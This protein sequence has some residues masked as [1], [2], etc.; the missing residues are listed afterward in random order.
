[1]LE[2]EENQ[3]EKEKPKVTYSGT[4]VFAFL[5]AKNEDRQV[6]NLPRAS[7]G[8]RQGLS[9][10]LPTHFVLWRHNATADSHDNSEEIFPF[11]NTSFVRT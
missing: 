7:F 10:S 9:E 6:E 5:V 8:R 4:L 11:Y 1:M 2:G 3:R